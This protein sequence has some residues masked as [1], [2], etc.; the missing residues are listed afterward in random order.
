MRLIENHILRKVDD[1]VVLVPL[2]N[3][4][5]DFYGMIV[6]NHTG[7]IICK[8]LE[9]DVD[10]EQIVSCLMQEYEIERKQVEND[11]EAFLSQLDSCHM[12][13]R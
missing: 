11:V 12:L 6:V 5:T 9:E 7:E 8:M 1:Q 3:Q 10:V 2:S 13:I 4:E